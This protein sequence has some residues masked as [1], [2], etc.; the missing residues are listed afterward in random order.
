MIL[1]KYLVISTRFIK[2]QLSLKADVKAETGIGVLIIFIAMVLV[3]A[4]AASVLIH[5]A[6]ILQQKASSTGTT[7]IRQVSSGIIETQ[8]LGY[9]S[10]HPTEA[11]GVSLLAIFVSPNAGN[12]AI[13]L[14]NV[15]L[16]LTVG[17]VTAV[18]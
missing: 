1:S 5:T 9:D 12:S 16:T 15:S 17:G 8:I 10:A 4:V 7:T 18:L 3:A 14:G 11:G 6:G 13:D 2:K